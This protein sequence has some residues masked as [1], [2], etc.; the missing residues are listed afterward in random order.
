MVWMGFEP[1]KEESVAKGLDRK[2][3]PVEDV[4]C[5]IHTFMLPRLQALG[6]SEEQCHQ[7]M[8]ENPRNFFENKRR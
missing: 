1:E 7:L 5:F 4:Y 6:V 2:G 8:H 3:N